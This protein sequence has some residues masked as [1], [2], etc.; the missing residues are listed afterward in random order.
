MW[1][2][3][4]SLAVL[5]ALARQ[6]STYERD[7][8]RCN[9]LGKRWCGPGKTGRVRPSAAV[10]V[11]AK[12]AETPSFAARRAYTDLVS[13]NRTEG[14]LWGSATP[15]PT[16]GASPTKSKIA[17]ATIS[18]QSCRVRAYQIPKSNPIGTTAIN[19]GMP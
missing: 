4:P 9:G 3:A 14:R 5:P 16:L 17:C 11:S 19:P 8:H 12:P 18:G 1:S 13:R 6:T 2:R 10:P 15:Q 7:R